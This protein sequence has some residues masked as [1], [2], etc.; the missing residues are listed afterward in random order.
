MQ[1]LNLRPSGYEPDELL[2]I[3]I[4]T[5]PRDINSPVCYA[6]CRTIIPTR[7]ANGSA[8]IVF[9]IEK[10]NIFDQK[11]I[12][13]N[14]N[15]KSGFVSI[16]GKPNVGKSTLMNQL[17]GEKL[18]VAT[19][20]A[21]TTRHRIMGILNSDDYQIVY[22]DTPGIIDP[23]YELQKSMMKFVSYALEDADII[24]FITDP[25]VNYE[26]ESYIEVLKK[27]DIPVFLV[28][29]KIDL[30]PEQEQTAK[31]KDWQEII[32][33]KETVAVS[34]ID[35]TNTPELLN[36][37]VENLPIHPPYYPEDEMTDRTER[38]FASEILR[39]KIFENYKKEIPYSCEVVIE[40]FKESKDI[41]RLRA[42]IYVE[43]TSQRA[44]LLGH[45]GSRIKEVG[46]GSRKEMEEFFGKKIYLEQHISVEPNWRKNAKKL[47]K[48]GY[49]Q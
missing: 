27:I 46:I 26:N 43:R 3:V 1:D 6:I 20:K 44:I 4:G 30:I 39:G 16:I 8:K 5:P 47:N 28:F 15:H 32:K 29:N 14:T 37:I 31:I 35:G 18:S 11:N 49:N 41:I 13:P 21:Q 42:I 34:A 19:S 36:K 22:S 25:Y 9:G 38:F 33:P 48:F 12:L 17:T 10:T 40:E 45:K 24:L 7:S 23:Q 2:P